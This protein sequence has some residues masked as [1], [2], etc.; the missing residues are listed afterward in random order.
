MR[1]SVNLLGGRATGEGGQ[2]AQAGEQV[3][4]L[5]L[6]GANLGVR[7]VHAGLDVVVQ[8]LVGHVAEGGL[9]VDLV[10]LGGAHHVAGN[11]HADF[12]DAGDIGVEEAA[13]HLL[14]GQG[15]G[16]GFAGGVDHVVGDPD[17]LGQDATKTDTGEHVHVVALAGVVGV[18]LALGV[19]EG[20][21][22]EGRAGGEEAAAVGVLDGGL[23]VA[24][25]LGGGVGQGED[26]GG[27][28]PVGHLAED[29]G[30]EDTTHGGQTHQDGG[31]DMVDDLL[32]GLELL[33][34]VVLA[35]EEDLVVGEL[36][37][38]VSGD[39]TLGV[40]EVEAVAS[41]LLGHALADEEVNNL[42]GDADTGRAGAEEDGAVVLAGETG[43][44]DGV[45]DSTEDDGAG[46][47]NVVIEAG[48]DTL[49]TLQCGEGILEVLKLNDDTK[50][51]FPLAWVLR[52][53]ISLS[54]GVYPG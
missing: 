5:A 8:V 26:D 11:D 31:L 17:G 32:K 33:A 41:I 37:T 27:G 48:V 25:G 7:V 20:H 42:L 29:L 28:V 4:D 1:A 36:V 10:L 2:V 24:L 30:S 22:G 40:D 46:T 43:T 9:A 21:G 13:L 34:I 12:A 38:T 3:A 15:L 14:G 53:C 18:G 49:V 44:L 19:G 50:L 51:S 23:E 52:P 45:D 6:Q 47:L 39:E 35:G 54:P 16:E